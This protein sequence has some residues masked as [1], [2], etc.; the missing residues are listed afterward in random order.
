MKSLLIWFRKNWQFLT[1]VVLAVLLLKRQTFPV[2]LSP[3]GRRASSPSRLTTQSVGESIERSAKSFLPVK[4][5]FA[6]APEVKRRLVVQ[7]SRVSL[8][9]K[10]VKRVQQDIIRKAEQLDGYMVNSRIDSPEGVD[11]GSV[12]VRVPAEKLGDYLAYIRGLGVRVVSENLVGRDV[13]DEYVD[14]Q[15][16]LDT[17]NKTK[18]KFEEILEK[19]EK[20]QDIL[21]VQRELINL[22]QQI[23]NLKGRQK[24]LQSNAQMV[25]VTVY[26]STD[27]LSLPYS[28]THP[29]RP[30]V[31]FKRAV[32]S[33]IGTARFAGTAVI[34]LLVYSV[35]WL[36]LLGIIY[37]IKRK[38]KP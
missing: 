38:K 6:P 21:Q 28:P 35:I 36:P 34:W 11:S 33:L 32:R 16:R 30:S 8:L 9:V 5:E 20:V 18:S 25:K 4:D 2:P 3:L 14:I 17:L 19:A 27:E 12:T 37:L 26:L 10:N 13:T 29:W 24:Y 23:D 1:I 22:Q 31:I 15:A 7:N